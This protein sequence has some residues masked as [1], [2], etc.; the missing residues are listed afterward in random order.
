ML[1]FARGFPKK[2]FHRQAL[3]L[4][5]LM[6]VMSS[7]SAAQKGEFIFEEAP[8]SSCHASTLVELRNGDLLAAWFGGTHE[9]SRNVAIWSSF[10]SAGHWSAPVELVREKNTP[11]WNPVLFHTKDGRLWLYYKFGT[12]PRAWKAAR[13]W[14]DD[15]GKSWSPPERLPRGILGPIRAKPLVLED[16]TVVSGSSVESDHYWNVWIERSTDNGKTWKKSGPITVPAS[17]SAENAKISSDE[18]YGIIQPSI[19]SL[20]G[21]HLRLYARSSPHIGRICVADS[22]DNGEAWSHARPIDLPNPDSGIDGIRLLD[23]RIVL[24]FNNSRTERTPLNLAISKDGE[25]FRVFSTLED[26]PG[27]YSYPAIILGK[28]GAIHITYTWNR[29]RIRYVS[30]PA[31]QIPEE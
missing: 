17:P 8:F 5:G 4:L 14:S 12:G 6:F 31:S 16:G 11:T 10:R 21:E 22:F 29:K 28:N 13:R 24:I 26:T 25:H 15:E 19:V 7:S 2:I 30:L 3:A 18:P 9:G 23:S 20:G 27:E 1:A